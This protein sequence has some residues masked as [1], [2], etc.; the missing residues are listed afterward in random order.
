MHRHSLDQATYMIERKMHILDLELNLIPTTEVS[1][2][3]IRTD[4]SSLYEFLCFLTDGFNYLIYTY[5]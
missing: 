4:K 2:G 3:L 5:I 1:P